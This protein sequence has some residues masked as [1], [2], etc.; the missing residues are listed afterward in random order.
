MNAWHRNAA[1][2]S[3]NESKEA[4]IRA[5]SHEECDLVHGGI[6]WAVMQRAVTELGVLLSSGRGSSGSW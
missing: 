6:G 4:T 1:R 3:S 5:L 2:E